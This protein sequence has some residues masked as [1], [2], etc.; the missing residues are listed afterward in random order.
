LRICL[1]QLSRDH[2]EIL[3]L[4]YY[5]EKSV[6]EVAQVIQMPKS[7]VKTRMFYA[8][9]RLAHCRRTGTSITPPGGLIGRGV[10]NHSFPWAFGTTSD[11][12]G[13]VALNPIADRGWIAPVAAC[14]M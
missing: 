10:C 1:A 13:D 7:T 6:E 9:K 3:D 8:R 5:Q 12:S 2:R 4:V 14:Q 11:G